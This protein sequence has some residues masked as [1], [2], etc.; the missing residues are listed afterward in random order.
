MAALLIIML[1]PVTCSLPSIFELSNDLLVVADFIFCSFPYYKSL[2][3]LALNFILFV[4]VHLYSFSSAY[5]N[6]FVASVCPLHLLFLEGFKCH[7][8]S[9]TLLS[10]LF[11]YLYQIYV[12]GI[13]GVLT[14]TPGVRHLS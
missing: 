13:G 9:T 2:H 11:R 10:P 3:L 6:H 1:R 4:S 8:Q 5:V 14:M 12:L 7:Q